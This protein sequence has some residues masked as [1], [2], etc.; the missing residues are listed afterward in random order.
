MLII[1][2]V[3]LIDVIVCI[4]MKVAMVIIA[5]AYTITF[6]NVV[7][8]ALAGHEGRGC[9]CQGRVSASANT[10]KTQQFPALSKPSGFTDECWQ[11]R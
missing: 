2:V 11:L 3:I 9:S 1:V 5:I 7:E 10:F 4:I 6:H 8:N